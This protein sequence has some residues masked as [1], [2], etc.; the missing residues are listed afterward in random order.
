[1]NFE[2]IKNQRKHLTKAMKI[3]FLPFLIK[4][5]K[6]FFCFYCKKPLEFNRYVN[7]HAND[8]RSDNRPANT[9]LA[10]SS[11]NNKKPHSEEMQKIAQEKLKENEIYSN[12]MSDKKIKNENLAQE[13]TTEIEIN[14][15]NTDIT[16]QYLWDNTDEH[17]R[18]IPFKDTLNSLVYIC[19]KRTGHGSQPAVRNYIAYLTSLEAPFEI[20]RDENGKKWIRRKQNV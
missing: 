9:L 6:G 12:F 3:K 17:G 16:E 7:E 5:D 15:S 19:K 10:C 18:R 1:M 14:E 20:V 8:D 11:C 13:T 4:R 2:I